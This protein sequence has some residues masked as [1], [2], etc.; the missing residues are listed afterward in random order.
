MINKINIALTFLEVQHLDGVAK[1]KE[2]G[3]DERK[4]RQHHIPKEIVLDAQVVL[5]EL[6]HKRVA[7]AGDLERTLVVAKLRRHHAVDGP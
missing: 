5:Q 3:D 4:V 6:L 1:H 2:E 7:P